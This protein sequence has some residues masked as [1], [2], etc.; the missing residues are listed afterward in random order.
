MSCSK[1]S[2]IISDNYYEQARTRTTW[3]PG[4]NWKI[5]QSKYRL[6]IMRK[7][8]KISIIYKYITHGGENSVEPSTLTK[9]VSS[10]HYY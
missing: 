1:D 2:K 3:R 7:Y 8:P 5:L 6:G 4:T 9:T 10:L